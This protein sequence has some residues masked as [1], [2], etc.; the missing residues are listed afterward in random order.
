MRQLSD[1]EIK[2]KELEL[3]VTFDEFCKK[4]DLRYFLCGG[5]LLGAIRHKGFIPWDDDIDLGMPRPDYEKLVELLKN[6]RELNVLAYEL[7]NFSFPYM[8]I[9]N[10]DIWVKPYYSEEMPKENLWIDIFPFDGLPESIDEGEKIYKKVKIL[11]TLALLAKSPKGTGKTLFKRVVRG[12]AKRVIN[13]YGVSRLSARL[14][15]IGL[16][17]S[18]ENSRWV[19]GVTWSLHGIGERM[20][21]RQFEVTEFKEF[22]KQEFP[23]FA[24]WIEYLTGCYGNYMELPPENKRVNHG[25]KAYIMESM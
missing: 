21:K 17:N 8:K 6:K 7:G 4:Y 20:E 14:R 25:L 10:P 12:I 3:L 1:E 9:I 16:S 5:T 19:G 23:V 18:Y 2:V 24:S 15:E 13:L 22:E 11:V